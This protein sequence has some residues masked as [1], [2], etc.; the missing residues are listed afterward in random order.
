MINAIALID[1]IKRSKPFFQGARNDEGRC[2]IPV[3]RTRALKDAGK[4]SIIVENEIFR[5]TIS[6]NAAVI[7][8]ARHSA[9]GLEVEAERLLAIDLGLD[10]LAI[11]RSESGNDVLDA[12][13]RSAGASAAVRAQDPTHT[14]RHIAY[15]SADASARQMQ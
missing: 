1:P 13:A 15:S 5:C 7:C 14:L 11:G 8:H 12:P 9:V 4:C 10:R 3:A 6:R 2:R